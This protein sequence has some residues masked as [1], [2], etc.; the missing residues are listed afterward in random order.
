MLLMLH[1]EDSM[2]VIFRDSKDEIKCTTGI[3]DGHCLTECKA[4]MTTE[5][6]LLLNLYELDFRI[7][8]EHIWLRLIDSKELPT[9]VFS[10]P[11][12]KIGY[13]YYNWKVENPLI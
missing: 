11:I 8:W 7:D 13:V 9:L 1:T 4:P 6:L 12:D 3:L 5:N 2:R 10:I